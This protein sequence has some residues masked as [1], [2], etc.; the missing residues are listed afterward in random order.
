[1]SF[2]TSS[3]CSRTNASSYCCPCSSRATIFTHTRVPSTH[4]TLTDRLVRIYLSVS[5]PYTHVTFDRAF[6]RT[7]C[8]FGGCWSHRRSSA[9]RLLRPRR[10]SFQTAHA[11]VPRSGV[12]LH[13]GDSRL[14]LCPRMASQ[15]QPQPAHQ[16]PLHRE[17]LPRQRRTLLLLYV[18]FLETAQNTADRLKK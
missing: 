14:V 10:H 3:K 6:R 5:L 13:R 9:D 4:F 12:C 2:K 16:T 1:M 18:V 8:N 11:W 7:E 15:V 17:G